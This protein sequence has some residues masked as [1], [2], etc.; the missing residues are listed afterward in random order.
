MNKHASNLPV[1]LVRE[2]KQK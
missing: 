1:M 2:G